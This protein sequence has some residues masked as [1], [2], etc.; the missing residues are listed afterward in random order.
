MNRITV[1]PSDETTWTFS[2]ADWCTNE[3]GGVTL[4]SVTLTPSAS[5]TVSNQSAVAANAVTCK[6]VA[7]ASGKITAT[8]SMSDGNTR[9]RT[10]TITV[11]NL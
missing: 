1:D 8:F 9:Q 10:L 4:S 2:A 6:F 3:G 7:S 11:A 5:V